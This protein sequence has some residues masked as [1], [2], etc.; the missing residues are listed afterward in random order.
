MGFFPLLSVSQN[1]HNKHVLTLITQNRLPLKDE[2]DKDE[3]DKGR[4]RGEGEGR[5]VG[6]GR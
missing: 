1:V 3:E 6:A 5:G 4:G 2:E